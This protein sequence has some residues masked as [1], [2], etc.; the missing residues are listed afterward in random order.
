MLLS[1]EP[2]TILTHCISKTCKGLGHLHSQHII[3]RDIK[4]DN[5]LLDAQGH[6]KIS[7]SPSCSVL[8]AH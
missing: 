6:V 5:V 2:P 7:M 1:W 8:N 4:S 3:H